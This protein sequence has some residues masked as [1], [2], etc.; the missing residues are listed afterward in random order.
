MDIVTAVQLK[1]RYPGGHSQVGHLAER[2]QDLL[3]HALAEVALV[4]V[5][6]E[7]VKW[8]DGDGGRLVVNTSKIGVGLDVAGAISSFIPGAQLTYPMPAP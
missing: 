4:V 5:F 1:R 3:G 8:Q 7:V 2:V 6:T